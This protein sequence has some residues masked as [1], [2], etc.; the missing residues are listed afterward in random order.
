MAYQN[1]NRD[2][3]SFGRPPHLILGTGYFIRDSYLLVQADLV[4][5]F[6]LSCHKLLC[7]VEELWRDGLEELVEV[8]LHSEGG[9]DVVVDECRAKVGEDPRRVFLDVLK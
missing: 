9:E 1:E 6:L 5:L 3:N 4:P 8:P 7:D 2:F